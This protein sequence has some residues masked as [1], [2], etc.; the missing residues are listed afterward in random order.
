M[1]NKNPYDSPITASSA[2][3]SSFAP[4]LLAF[5]SLLAG[6]ALLVILFVGGPFVW[7]LRDGLGP[8]AANSTWLEAMSRMFWTFY[9]G[10]ATIAA[11]LILVGSSLLRIR[12]VRSAPRR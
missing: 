9:W 7:L 6:S 3:R 11:A 2:K 5:V 1:T 10:P 4:L 8:D 12:L